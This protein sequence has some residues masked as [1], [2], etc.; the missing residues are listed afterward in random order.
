MS[1]QSDCINKTACLVDQFFDSGRW[2]PFNEAQRLAED[3]LGH[4]CIDTADRRHNQFFYEICPVI[5][6][7]GQLGDAGS[8]LRF[9]GKNSRFD[10][11]YR[12][13]T[14]V[15]KVEMVAAINGWN[16]ALQMEL[17]DKCRSAPAF[18]RIVANGLKDRRVFSD[19]VTEAIEFTEYAD[20]TLRPL[21]SRA[22]EKK[23][24]IA[25]KNNSYL[26]AVLGIV[27]DDYI[28]PVDSKKKGAFDPIFRQEFGSNP[29]NWKPFSRVFVVGVS[30]RYL[31]D[32]MKGQSWI[33]NQDNPADQAS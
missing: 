20:K 2:F 14:S 31:F 19:N 32:A 10:A 6:I 24:T 26:G 22:L 3:V 16:D 30:G 23:K 25:S 27:F 4:C 18:Q 29:A 8:E 13:Q 17:L 15:T 7:A 12:N 33:P 9:C 11:E 1:L 28:K 21:V 5:L